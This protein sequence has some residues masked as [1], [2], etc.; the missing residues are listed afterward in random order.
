MLATATETLH[1]LTDRVVKMAT[2][3][4]SRIVI[5]HSAGHGGTLEELRQLHMTQNGWRDIGYHCII[6]N[7]K[8]M[9]GKP[10]RAAACG[11][12]FYGRPEH[13]TG[14]HCRNHN[15]GTLGVCVVGDYEANVPTEGQL[16]SLVHVLQDWCVRYDIPATYDYIKGHRQMSG[17][18]ANACPGKHLLALLPSVLVQVDGYLMR[19]RP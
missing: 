10:S 2:R 13:V 6:T 15:I 3:D 14:A 17:H 11:A 7:G 19:A 9:G 18:R 1:R 4:I 16:L 8:D 5:H 12:I